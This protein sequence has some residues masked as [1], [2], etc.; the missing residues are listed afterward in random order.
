MFIEILWASMLA[1][2]GLFGLYVKVF[3]KSAAP[4]GVLG[5]YRNYRKE[6]REAFLLSLRRAVLKEPHIT[7]P[8]EACGLYTGRAMLL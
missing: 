8:E 5:R 7:L 3:H 2:L 4:W 1:V 6:R